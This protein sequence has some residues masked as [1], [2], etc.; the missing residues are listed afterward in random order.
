MMSFLKLISFVFELWL[1]GLSY[2]AF[3]IG[4]FLI[5]S[6]SPLRWGKGGMGVD[7]ARLPPHLNPPPPRGEEV[8]FLT[9]L[10]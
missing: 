5:S 7:V 9:Q 1:C 2:H 3:R 4:R 6:P 10:G 8:I